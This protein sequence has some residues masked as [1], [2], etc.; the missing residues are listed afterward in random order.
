MLWY[1]IV[2]LV[3]AVPV[4]VVV[5]GS[6]LQRSPVKSCCQYNMYCINWNVALHFTDVM[7]CCCA[8]SQDQFM[9]SDLL[10]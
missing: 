7:D 1:V 8:Q 4:P 10:N 5:A 2:N 3:S 9:D 6:L